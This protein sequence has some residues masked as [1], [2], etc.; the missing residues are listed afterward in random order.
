MNRWPVEVARDAYVAAVARE[1]AAAAKVT[2]AFA[3]LERAQA[4]SR[5]ASQDTDALR[6]EWETLETARLRA[7]RAA[8]TVQS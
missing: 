5:K 8:E 4:R 7:Q 2:A 3:A 6:L 1:V